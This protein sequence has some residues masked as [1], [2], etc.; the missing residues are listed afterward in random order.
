[1]PESRFVTQN[2]IF[3]SLSDYET[4][5]FSPEVTPQQDIMNTSTRIQ[6]TNK[7]A[8]NKPNQLTKPFTK[9]ENFSKNRANSTTRNRNKE[10]LTMM[11]NL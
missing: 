7:P 3:Q 4:N 2:S 8:Q 9:Q 10:L 11:Q 1:M 6:L 5:K